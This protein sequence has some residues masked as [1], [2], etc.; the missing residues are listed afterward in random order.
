M[1]REQPATA[2]TKEERKSANSTFIGRGANQDLEER[3]MKAQPQ[4]GG[5]H[6]SGRGNE[7]CM[8]RLPV[9]GE[10]GRSR[11]KARGKPRTILIRINFFTSGGKD[12]LFG[13]KELN[14][15]EAKCDD[16]DRG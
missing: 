12:G 5:V 10:K 13:W 15:P 9:K 6:E 14:F 8:G 2:K 4:G 7:K 16:S 3:C 1:H 11:G